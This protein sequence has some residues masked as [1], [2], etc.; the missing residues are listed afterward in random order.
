MSL[1]EQTLKLKEIKN[2]RLA[3]L[4]VLGFFVQAQTTGK[5]PLDNLAAHLADPWYALFTN[6]LSPL[7]IL[8]L[9]CMPY[10]TE[11]LMDRRL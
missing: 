7:A 5:T 10:S 11:L 6:Q 3:M 8:Q 1:A 9:A 2:A 4:G